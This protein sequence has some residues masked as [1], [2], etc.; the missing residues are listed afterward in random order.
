[1]LKIFQIT[2]EKDPGREAIRDVMCGLRAPQH[3]KAG[4]YEHVANV[5]DDDLEAA[6]M[7]MNRWT[8]ADE[9]LVERLAPLHSLSVGDVVVDET[10]KA[11]LVASFGFEPVE[12]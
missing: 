4:R 9:A 11:H 8:N 3:W 10:G 12:G 5:K 7:V 1:M 6:F 2:E